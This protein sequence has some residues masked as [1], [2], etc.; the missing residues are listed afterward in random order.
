MSYAYLMITSTVY[1]I[2]MYNVIWSLNIAK[3]F[4]ICVVNINNHS[5]Y[6]YFLYILEKS[7]LLYYLYVCICIFKFIFVL[8]NK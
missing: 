6:K 2:V 1:I 7:S 4:I 8:E 5:E 3:G